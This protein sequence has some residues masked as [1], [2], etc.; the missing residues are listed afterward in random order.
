M[1]D[2]NIKINFFAG[3]LDAIGKVV[4]GIKGISNI[5]TQAREEIRDT[6]SDTFKML[7]ST[8]NVVIFRLSEILRISDE[9]DFKEAVQNLPYDEKWKAVEREMRLCSSLR[10]SIVEWKRPKSSFINHISTSDW[11]EAVRLMEGILNNE[12][13]LAGYIAGTFS[14]LLSEF[15][16]YNYEFTTTA[17][18]GK[19]KNKI[20]E[21]RKGLDGERLTL[22][23]MEIDLINMV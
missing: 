10:H 13:A 16:M 15:N 2:L 5:P 7:D 20:Q 6:L 4:A 23:Q 19:I 22:I 17:D 1:P 18:F 21:I 9:I 11:N 14:G 3:I 8:I 12:T